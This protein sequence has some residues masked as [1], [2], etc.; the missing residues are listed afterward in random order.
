MSSHRV[1]LITKSI[2]GFVLLFRTTDFH[3]SKLLQVLARKKN[4]SSPCCSRVSRY[5]YCYEYIRCWIRC[6]L[7]TLSF[8]RCMRV[9]D[10]LNCTIFEKL[11]LVRV[12]LNTVNNRILKSS[13]I[14]NHYRLHIVQATKEI[15]DRHCQKAKLHGLAILY[16]PPGSFEIFGA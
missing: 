3:Y 1:S 6:A 12:Y 2:A 7:S 8:T 15:S 14:F 16:A 11:R 13:R 10:S 5:K 4:F 9:E